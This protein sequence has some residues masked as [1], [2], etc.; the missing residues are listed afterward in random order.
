MREAQISAAPLLLLNS[1]QIVQYRQPSV[2]LSLFRSDSNSIK[3]DPIIEFNNMILVV[4]VAEVLE[5]YAELMARVVEQMLRSAP[6][7][8]RLRF[9]IP[10]FSPRSRTVQA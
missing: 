4:I 6:L 8:R 1:D 7:P 2:S 10:L 9:L 5:E 3:P